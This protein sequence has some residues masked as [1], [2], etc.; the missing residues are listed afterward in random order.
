MKTKSKISSANEIMRYRPK[1]TLSIYSRD[2]PG[3]KK[4]QVGKTYTFTVT[5]KVTAMNVGDSEYAEDYD[6][7]DDGAHARLR[8]TKIKE[9]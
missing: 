9:C 8:V 2:L 3:L 5:A 4:M 6:R 1:P 7:D